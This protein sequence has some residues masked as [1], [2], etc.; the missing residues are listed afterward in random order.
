VNDRSSDGAAQIL[1]AAQERDSRLSVVNNQELPE[2]WL[3]KPT[4]LLQGYEASCG[5]WLLF[6]DADVCFWPDAIRRAISLVRAKQ[7]DHL[8]LMTDVEMRGFWEK[9]VLTFF[10]LGFHIATNP[11]GVSDPRS[12]AYVGIGAFQLV[13]RTVYEASGTH[14]RLATEVLDDMKLAKIVK[15]SGF[16]SGVGIAQD[17]VTKRWHAGIGNIVRGVTNNFFAAR[18]HRVARDVLSAG[19]T[20]AWNRVMQCNSL[21]QCI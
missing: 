3:G 17:F 1:H 9:T 21:R 11:R 14:R 19:Q 8:T 16:R 12:R 6:T 7:L 4:A 18:Q 2:G 5:E 10:G 20:A 13:R 15:Q